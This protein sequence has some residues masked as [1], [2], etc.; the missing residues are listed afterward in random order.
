MQWHQRVAYG[1]ATN[2]GLTCGS[3]QVFS[4]NN[5]ADPDGS[6]GFAASTARVTG[7]ADGTLELMGKARIS[8]LGPVYMN[9]NKITALAAGSVS[10]ASTDAINGSQLFG[11]ASST[12]SALGGG[13]TVNAD[14]TISA[15]SYSVG[16]AKV[17]SAG[18]AIANL[19]GR[20]T[21]NTTNI[22]QNT[23]DITKLQGQMAD[24]VTYDSP[25]R[26][27]VTLGGTGSSAPVALHNVKAGDVSSASTDAINGS[28]LHATASSTASALGGGS[29]VNADGTVNAPTYSV[30]GTKLNNVGDAITNID[31]RTTQNT[32]DITKVQNQINNGSIGL[33]QQDPTTRDITVGKDTDGTLMNVAG[34]AGNRTV[35]GVAAG[36]VNAASVDAINGGQLFGLASGTASAL[37]G[38]STVNADGTISTPSYHV[39]GTTVHSV[40]DAVTNLDGRTSTNTNNIAQNTTDITSLQNQLSERS[41]GLVVQDPTT[42]NVT[43][44]KD[45]DG[46]VVDV[47]G[48]EGNRTV[49]GVAAGA[50]NAASVDAINGSQLYGTASSMAAALGGGSTVNANGTISAPSYNIGGTLFNNVGGAL[51]NLDGRVTRNTTDISS[52]MSQMTDL[53]TQ[54]SNGRSNNPYFNATDTSS[55]NGSTDGAVAN[56]AVPG[57]GV[58]STVAGS[59]AVA[60][61]DYATAVGANASAMGTGAT[62]VGADAQAAHRNSVALGQGSVTDRDNSVSVGSAAQQRQITN[63]AAGTAATDAVNVGQMNSAVAQGVSQANGHSDQLFNQANHAINDVARNAYAGIAAAMA[64]PNMPPSG[65]GRTIVAAG[66]ATYKGGSAAAVGATYRSRNSKWLVN[67]AASV[68][69]TGDAGVRAQV[70]YEF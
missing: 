68:T 70:G 32:S 35:T 19:D 26:D 53:S 4:L 18:D 58:G 5:A 13:S 52:I 25:A 61:N 62:A 31:N 54:M 11:L 36:A 48:T 9:S 39:G 10:A 2:G 51:T 45:T 47:T 64:M 3:N 8:M 34:T 40:G 12:A 65:P 15:P 7:Y 59:N 21:T 30:G 33:V 20:M 49:T 37:G 27:T 41:I 60:S 63:V 44:G 57:P 17:N 43:V 14:G 22:A 24:A 56:V 1:A 50:V 28:Q 23:T 42:R 67:G 16:G 46:T 38:G 55:A 69:S 29:T 66:G 6:T